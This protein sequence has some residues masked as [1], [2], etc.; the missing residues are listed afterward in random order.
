MY[1]GSSRCKAPGS[2]SEQPH[3]QWDAHTLGFTNISLLLGRYP[4]AEGREV[5]MQ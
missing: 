1:S 3:T 4:N 5:K 2:E